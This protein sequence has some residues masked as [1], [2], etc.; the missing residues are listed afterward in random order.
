MGAEILRTLHPGGIV[1]LK[2]NIWYEEE[3]D[4]FYYCGGSW[5]DDHIDGRREKW[6][7]LFHLSQARPELYLRMDVSARL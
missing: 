7:N 2:V 6:L 5:L 4:D 3:V 1:L